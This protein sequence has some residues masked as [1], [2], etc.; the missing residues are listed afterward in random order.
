MKALHC[1]FPPK[2]GTFA[3]QQPTKNTSVSKFDRTNVTHI[4]TIQIV[5]FVFLVSQSENKTVSN[6][7][8]SRKSPPRVSDLLG[9]IYYCG[10]T[11]KATAVSLGK[12]NTLGFAETNHPD[13]EA[14]SVTKHPRRIHLTWERMVFSSGINHRRQCPISGFEHQLSTANK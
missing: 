4:G 6:Q 8:C 7:R 10:V 9:V 3:Q 12:I 5:F 14:S 11:T 1:C 2:K 13:K